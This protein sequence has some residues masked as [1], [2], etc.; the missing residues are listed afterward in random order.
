MLIVHASALRNRFRQ[1][2]GKSVCHVLCYDARIEFVAR[3]KGMMN[4]MKTQQ[5]VFWFSRAVRGN[6]YPVETIFKGVN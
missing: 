1:D 3:E 2:G 5:S 4:K 6:L